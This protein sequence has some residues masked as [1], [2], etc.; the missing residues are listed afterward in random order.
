MALTEKQKLFCD[1]YLIDL[2]ATRAYKQVYE[3]CKS[4]KVAAASASRILT[5]PEVAEYIKKRMSD[6]EKRT[7][8]DQ[9]DIINELWSMLQ[10]D[11]TGVV[12]VVEENVYKMVRGKKVSITDEKGKPVTEKRVQVTPTSK[13]TNEQKKVI[14]GI[15]QGK[16]GIEVKIIDRIKGIELLGRHYGMF[17]DQ[18]EI[19]GTEE[20]KTKLDAI[21]SQMRGDEPHG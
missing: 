14:S 5:K 21:L 8:R 3:S 15:K 20:A 1:E 9:D 12:Q 7:E 10:A 13:W 16:N 18:V 4:E 2:N 17:K 19:S 6:R 11:Y